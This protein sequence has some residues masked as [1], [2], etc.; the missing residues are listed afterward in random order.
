MGPQWGPSGTDRTQ[1]GPMLASWALLSGTTMKERT[2]VRVEFKNKLYT[3]WYYHHKPF[4]VQGGVPLHLESSSNVILWRLIFA[5][6]N[7]M[8]EIRWSLRI[9]MLEIRWRLR[10]LMLEIRWR[11]RI[12]MLE[13]RW[14]LRILML[15]IRWRLRILMLEIRWRLRILML[16]IRGRLR[17]LMLEIIW[18]LRL[19]MLEIRWRLR[20]QD[21]RN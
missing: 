10:I 21:V 19:L 11:L 1:V 15:E 4:Y 2:A 8:L 13:I 7:N 12:L 14:R 9:L 17:I 16:E 3:V 20:I 18:R 6:V 5:D